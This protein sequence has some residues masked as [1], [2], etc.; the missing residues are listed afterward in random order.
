MSRRDAYVDRIRRLLTQ[1]EIR[2]YRI[3]HRRR[4]RRV[5]IAHGGGVIRFTFPSTPSDLE[6]DKE[7]RGRITP[8]T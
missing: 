4:H 5:V 1:H 3:E 8:G 2:D 7:Q 6:G